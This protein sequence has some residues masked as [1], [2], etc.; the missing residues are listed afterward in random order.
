MLLSLIIHCG[1]HGPSFSTLFF[2]VF[3][4]WHCFEHSKFT[5]PNSSRALPGLPLPRFR[6]L[7]WVSSGLS[8]NHPQVGYFRTSSTALVFQSRLPFCP[9]QVWS[10]KSKPFLNYPS[11]KKKEKDLKNKVDSSEGFF[12]HSSTSSS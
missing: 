5:P 1:Y 7:S 2:S 12:P 6:E 4:S 11:T 3:H 10:F 9:C 8:F